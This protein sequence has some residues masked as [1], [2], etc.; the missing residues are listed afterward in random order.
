M[1]GIS[2]CTPSSGSSPA[3]RR[4]LVSSVCVAGGSTHFEVAIELLQR[5]A[6]DLHASD[7]LALHLRGSL[8][9]VHHLVLDQR[10]QRAR[11]DARVRAQR[12][13]HIRE[14]V[15]AD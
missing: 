4:H 6:L 15:D 5:V 14:A 13:E 7:P 9:R 11:A 12:H 1:S 10:E 2:R 3:E 8:H